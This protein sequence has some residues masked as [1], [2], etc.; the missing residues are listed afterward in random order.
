MENLVRYIIRAFS[1]QERMAYL[2]EY[3]RIIYHTQDNRQDKIL[4][5]LDRLADMTFNIL[6]HGDR[7]ISK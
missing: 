5:T 2:A 4:D 6:N 3:S 1:S 7:T